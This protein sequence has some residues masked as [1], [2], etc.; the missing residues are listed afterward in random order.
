MRSTLPSGSLRSTGTT[1]VPSV[2][3]K[4]RPTTWS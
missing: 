3:S 1:L 2:D 4:T